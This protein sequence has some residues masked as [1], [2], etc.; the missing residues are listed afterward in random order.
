MTPGCVPAAWHPDSISNLLGLFPVGVGDLGG[1]DMFTLLSVFRGAC[2]YGYW[3]VFNFLVCSILP[4]VAEQEMVKD[5]LWS[6]I[7]QRDQ[8]VCLSCIVI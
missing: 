4:V 1:A 7:G 8:C 3:F 6:V 2:C 5:G